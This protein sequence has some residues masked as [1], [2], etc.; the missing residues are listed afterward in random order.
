MPPPPLSPPSTTSAWFIFFSRLTHLCSRAPPSLEKNIP[1]QTTFTTTSVWFISYYSHTHLCTQS[2]RANRSA[3]SY[4]S[5]FPNSHATMP[6]W[7]RKLL[8]RLRKTPDAAGPRGNGTTAPQSLA[9]TPSESP[10]PD[11]DQSTRA[12]D[13]ADHRAEEDDSMPEE[14]EAEGAISRFRRAQR[15]TAACREDL[16]QAE[17]EERELRLR[18]VAI[19]NKCWAVAYG[20]RASGVG[21]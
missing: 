21:S 10:P 20:P 18:L 12:D 17:E 6:R 9:E 13:V 7:L 2:S 3:S 15:E 11:Y 14:A 16:K 8:N 4:E 19:S 1:P 5:I